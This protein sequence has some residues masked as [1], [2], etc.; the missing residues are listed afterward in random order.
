[1]D[2]PNVP[3]QDRTQPPHLGAP[4]PCPAEP[5]PKDVPDLLPA[6][7]P[8]DVRHDA[9]SDPHVPDP[10]TVPPPTYVED[11][12]QEILMEIARICEIRLCLRAALVRVCTL[13]GRAILNLPPR[14]DEVQPLLCSLVLARDHG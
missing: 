13:T 11:V 10:T 3:P 12:W 4:T 1:M 14:T 5:E 9:P 8:T 6:I 7:P 2:A